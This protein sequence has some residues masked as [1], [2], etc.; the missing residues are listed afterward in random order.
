MNPSMDGIHCPPGEIKA[1]ADGIHY[2]PDEMKA[3]ADRIKTI[4][5]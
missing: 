5:G 3:I 1:I 4:R 2:P